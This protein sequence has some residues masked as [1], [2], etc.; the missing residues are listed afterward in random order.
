MPEW[1]PQN[2]TV[3]NF[4]LY[5]IGSTGAAG[6]HNRKQNDEHDRAVRQSAA[7]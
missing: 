7:A 6:R 4:S 5:P 2:E 1:C 3:P